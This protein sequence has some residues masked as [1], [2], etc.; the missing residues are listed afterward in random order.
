MR[1]YDTMLD[2]EGDKLDEM[3][4]DFI[5]MIDIPKGKTKT[6]LEYYKL[7]KYTGFQYTGNTWEAGMENWFTD[8]LTKIWDWIKSIFDKIANWFAGTEKK[9]EEKLE[10][11]SAKAKELVE[12][13]KNAKFKDDTKI[14]VSGKLSADG[15]KSF[16]DNGKL[17][18]LHLENFCKEEINKLTPLFTTIEE[19]VSALGVS[20]GDGETQS[21]TEA[22]RSVNTIN[23]AKAKYIDTV[24][25]QTE[26]LSAIGIKVDKKSGKL[27]ADIKALGVYPDNT[28][29]ST[30]DY[31][32]AKT[33]VDQIFSFVQ[34]SENLKTFISH[35]KGNANDCEKAVKTLEAGINK[36]KGEKNQKKQKGTVKY[37]QE[38][39]TFINS[40]MSC[41]VAPVTIIAH[42]TDQTQFILTQVDKALS[43]D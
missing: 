4:S 10:Q 9:T 8:M 5:I 38:A 35:N 34:L 24:V 23:A 13:M 19:Q 42:V 40:V 20:G 1:Q 21:G 25:E 26:S 31:T 15:L 7:D 27:S 32:K 43:T 18:F 30:S 37:L 17:V 39:K 41:F 3:M 6:G 12:K 28:I 2:Y 22:A 14:D 11:V 36:L 16:N 29:W 33:H